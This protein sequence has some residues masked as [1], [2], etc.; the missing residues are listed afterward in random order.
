MKYFLGIDGGGTK[1]EYVLADENGNVR[2]HYIGQ[3]SNPNDLG[4]ERVAN[5]IETDIDYVIG[6][7]YADNEIYIF[8]GISGAGVGS[9]GKQLQEKLS[10][11]YPYVKVESDL[12]NAIETSLQGEEGC[13]LICGTGISCAL[14]HD[15]KIDVFGGYGHLFER[16]GSGYSYGKDGILAALEDED[17]IGE[18][19][20][21]TEKISNRLNLQVPIKQALCEI[22]NKGKS[23]IASFCRMVF[24]CAYEGDAVCKRIV[25]R[26][27]N[28]A[29]QM[30]EKA[31][32]KMEKTESKIAF[33][34][35][36]TKERAFREIAEQRF[37]RDC[38]LVFSECSPVF[39][40]IRKSVEIW[41]TGCNTKF[42]ENYKKT[43]KEI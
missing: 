17:G 28:C 33:I 12:L 39:G 11:K 29:M 4:V 20:C 18:K 23:Y 2:S 13:V 6:R 43:I 10:V 31:V 41:G 9:L 38:E 7:E 5:N 30:I 35:S 34:G 19:T 37:G 32:S 3:G 36:V 16:G 40:A 21:L 24:E 14:F 42:V 15:G 8:A 27:V 22:Y 1:T 25:E 26:N